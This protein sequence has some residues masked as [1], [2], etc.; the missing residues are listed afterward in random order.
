MDL[1]E[2]DVDAG[3]PVGSLAC[4]VAPCWRAPG[5]AAMPAATQETCHARRTV[6][7][8]SRL[9]TQTGSRLDTI[10]Y[11]VVHKMVRSGPCWRAAAHCRGGRAGGGGVRTRAG[12]G[13]TEIALPSSAWTSGAVPRKEFHEHVSVPPQ[14][15]AGCRQPR[16]RP[17]GHQAGLAQAQGKSISATT[18]P[19]AWES[20]HRSILLPAFAKATGG[21]DQPRVVARGGHGLQ[22]RGVQGQPALRRDHPG[23]GPV[24]GRAVA[25]HLREDPGRQDA[26]PEGRAFQARRPARPRR[27]RLGPDHRH[28]LQHREDQEPAEVVERPAQ[29]RVQGPRRP[30]RAWAPR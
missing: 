27:L 19:G 11:S 22:G 20:A 14:A 16:C 1:V 25:G 23:R 6:L 8:P 13:G 5:C 3:C 29:A 26:L 12:P 2:S 15:V 21:L 9:W 24:P 17:L 7:D 10:T 18:Y 4:V 28:R 30:R